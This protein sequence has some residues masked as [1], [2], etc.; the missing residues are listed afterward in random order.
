MGFWKKWKRSILIVLLPIVSYLLLG[1]LEI[2]FGNKKD[3][4]FAYRDFFWPFLLLAIA[5]LIVISLVISLLPEKIN[6]FLG[7]LILGVGI[8]SYIQNMFMNIKLSEANGAPMNWAEL[9]SFP[10]INGIV[11]CAIIVVIVVLSFA[12]KKHWDAIAMGGGAFLSAI[13]LVAIVS[14]LVT[15][16]A[17]DNGVASNLQESGEK[18]LQVASDNNIIVFVLDTFGT[19]QIDSI[20]KEYPEAL[21]EFA[22]FTYYNN[23]DC[24]YY[25]TFPSMTHLLT[26]AEFDFHTTSEQWL[27]KSWASERA[28]NF[29]QALRAEKYECNLYSKEEGYVYGAMTNLE[30][31]FDNVK[32]L[33]Q[34]VYKWPLMKK[35]G[36]MSIYR[37]VPYFIKPYFEV[38]TKDFSKVT[39]IKEGRAVVDDN[40]EF[41]K[42]LTEEKLSISEDMENAFIIQHLFGAHAPY[43][44]D[45]N[46]Q[47]V[48][49]ATRLETGKG[50]LTIVSEYLQQLKNLEVYNS[51][52]IIV[53]ADHGAW[54]GGDTQPIFFIKE[55]DER[56]DKM[57]LNSAPISWDDFQATILKII[58]RDYSEYGTSIYD[59]KEGDQRERSVYMIQN[60]DAYPVVEGSTFNVYYKYMY[61]TDKEELDQKVKN[62]PDEVLPATPWQKIPW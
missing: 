23:A 60:D 36:K 7:A 1:P 59:W 27:E 14:L 54:H 12:V 56:H 25:V 40:G 9:G 34:V 39:D 35:L 55:K 17:A 49:E 62:G 6:R 22:D 18:Q 13:Q 53:M 52:T 37:Y 47:V 44:I 58:G 45:A 51:A 32:S 19:A 43:T 30:G 5:A 3:F 61:L 50:L 38:V 28:D 11:Y 57:L 46:A 29:F 15:A 21:D 31:K 41:Y 8:A 26:G 48:K 20:L 33:E 10:F 24:H 42:I 4:Q 16:P 2:Y